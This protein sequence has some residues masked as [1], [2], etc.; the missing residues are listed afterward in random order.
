MVE[1]TG[2]NVEYLLRDGYWVTE[3]REPRS[4]LSTGPSNAR[5]TRSAVDAYFDCYIHYNR[6]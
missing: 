6:R 3:P 5:H 2:E 1:Q 4:P